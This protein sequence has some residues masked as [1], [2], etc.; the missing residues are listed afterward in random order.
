MLGVYNACNPLNFLWALFSLRGPPHFLDYDKFHL[1]KP[2]NMK[3]R[4]LPHRLGCCLIKSGSCL[5]DQAT[6]YSK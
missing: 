3:I 2:E 4:R 1:T 5:I 6:A